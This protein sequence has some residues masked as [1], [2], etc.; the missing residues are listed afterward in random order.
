MAN[1][2]LLAVCN[3]T[4]KRN[5]FAARLALALAGAGGGHDR[6]TSNGEAANSSCT[7]GSRDTLA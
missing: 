4:P 7:T 5:G 6:E 1:R 3:P 2:K